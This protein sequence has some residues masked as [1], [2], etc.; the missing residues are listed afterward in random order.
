[1]NLWAH[2][3]ALAKLPAIAGICPHPT[4]MGETFALPSMTATSLAASHDLEAETALHFLLHKAGTSV[5][6]ATDGAWLLKSTWAH[7]RETGLDAVIWEAT[8]G[9]TRGD[10]R[11]FEHNSIEMIRIMR[12]TLVK[13]RILAPGARV[14][15]THLSRTLCAPHEEMVRRLAP[16]GL[17]PAYDG[18]GITVGRAAELDG[19]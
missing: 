19:V 13:Q 5:L 3:S 4:E 14:Y 10:W 18:L 6:Y 15:L 1:M 9:E 17:I 8:C 12:Q 11:I 2:P 7:L 16:E